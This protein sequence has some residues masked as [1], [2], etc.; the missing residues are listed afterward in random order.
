MDESQMRETA[1]TLAVKFASSPHTSAT[2]T[3]VVNTAKGFYE[4]LRGGGAGGEDVGE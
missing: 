4:F 2:T 1:L 3:Q